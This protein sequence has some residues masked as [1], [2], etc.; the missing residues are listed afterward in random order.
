MAFEINLACYWREVGLNLNSCNVLTRTK[1]GWDS[2]SIHT[3]YL[4]NHACYSYTYNVWAHT[5]TY[6]NCFDWN[7]PQNSPVH[8]RDIHYL[9]MWQL[10]SLYSCLWYPSTYTGITVPAQECACNNMVPLSNITHYRSRRL[11][12]AWR[13]IISDQ[14]ANLVPTPSSIHNTI[15]R[16]IWTWLC[17]IARTFSTIPS[18]TANILAIGNRI[19]YAQLAGSNPLLLSTW[20]IHTVFSYFLSFQR[21]GTT[22]SISHRQLN[23]SY[24]KAL[25][26][27][28]IPY[29]VNN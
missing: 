19:S 22:I 7:N 12:T 2:N 1:K 13:L 25:T 5:Y 28:I 20:H 18:N 9:I 15:A 11:Y 10:A 4:I 21:D 17:I 8:W 29:P 23:I 6:N 27:F 14:S 24:K 16:V 26:P 3:P